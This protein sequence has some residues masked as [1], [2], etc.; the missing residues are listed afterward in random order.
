MFSVTCSNLWILRMLGNGIC[1][2]K[3]HSFASG[4]TWQNAPPGAFPLLPGWGCGDGWEREPCWFHPDIQAYDSPNTCICHPPEVHSPITSHESY[5]PF[6]WKV[7]IR[8]LSRTSH[9][10]SSQEPHKSRSYCTGE[11]RMETFYHSRKFYW[12]TCSEP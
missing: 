9:M 4:F 1:L 8:F 10:S 3:I 12:T 2:S 5:V 7:K 6:K 11:C